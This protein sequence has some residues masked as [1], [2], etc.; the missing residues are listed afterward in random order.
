M[1]PNPD[2]TK[3]LE[4]AKKL[5]ESRPEKAE[6]LYKE[7]LLEGPGTGEAALRDYETALM[8]LGELYRDQKKP[9]ELAE[10]VR[11]SRSTLSS[12]AK[13]KTAKIGLLI[14]S[15]RSNSVLTSGCQFDSSLIYSPLYL[16]PPTSR[17]RSQ[18]HV[19]N[20]Q[21]QSGDRSCGKVSRLA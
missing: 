15:F 20:G 9:N 2:K 4:E 18:S 5:T 12:F 3:R 11:T 8:G 16:T 21:S 13:A 19:S 7:I 1:A 14:L 6:D 17:Y 10:L